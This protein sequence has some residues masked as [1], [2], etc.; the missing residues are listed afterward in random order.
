MLEQIYIYP[1]HLHLDGR[2]EIWELTWPLPLTP[3]ISAS[4][5]NTRFTRCQNMEHTQVVV[6]K[7]EYWMVL[8]WE[9]TLSIT[10]PESPAAPL[11]GASA[12]SSSKKTTHGRA[13]LACVTHK[14]RSQDWYFS[15]IRNTFA[16]TKEHEN[17]SPTFWK[18]SRTFFSDS[19]MYMLMSS[20]PLTLR[21]FN[22]HSVAT[23]LASNVC[24]RYVSGLNKTLLSK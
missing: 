16:S 8:T 17:R 4:I 19:P 11:A 21:K 3:S 23:A 18:I 6:S 12:S 10:P 14:S 20:G 15:T 2:A 24:N 7:N 13:A 9:T 22:E 5:W 1:S